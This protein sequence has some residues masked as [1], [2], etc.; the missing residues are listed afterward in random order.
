MTHPPTACAGIVQ[1]TGT[2][3]KSEPDNLEALFLRGLA[4]FHLDDRDM[5]KRHFS[6][7]SWPPASLRAHGAAC[8]CGKAPLLQGGLPI[9]HWYRCCT[10]AAPLRPS[11]LQWGGLPSAPDPAAEQMGLRIPAC[12]V[13]PDLEAC[14]LETTLTT[15]PRCCRSSSL[16]P[17]TGQPSRPSTK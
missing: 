5:A 3:L 15:R 17:T 1:L 12:S 4:Y 10:A 11:P 6:E 9:S 16:T 2:I 8:W 14:Q 7:V 13:K